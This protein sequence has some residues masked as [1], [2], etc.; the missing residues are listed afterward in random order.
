MDKEHLTYAERNKIK[1]QKT[2]FK[3]NFPGKWG[4][5]GRPRSHR[6]KWYI[7]QKKNQQREVLDKLLDFKEKCKI[8]SGFSTETFNTEYSRTMM[9]QVLKKNG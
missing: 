4:T 9:I 6:F 3:E 5:E 7:L 2:I 1:E 8:K